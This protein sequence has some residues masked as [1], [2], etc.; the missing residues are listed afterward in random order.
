MDLKEYWGE[1]RKHQRN[2][3]KV[4][5]AYTMGDVYRA[6]RESRKEYRDHRFQT[7]HEELKKLGITYEVKNGGHHVILEFGREK[8]DFWPASGKYFIRKERRYGIGLHRLLKH[9]QG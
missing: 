9:F 1:H 2:L 5:D 3:P 7:H 6:M 4:D 8:A